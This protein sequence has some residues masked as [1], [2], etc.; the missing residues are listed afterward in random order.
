MIVVSVALLAVG[1]PMASAQQK[2]G[3]MVAE[4]GY[5]WMAG[6]WVA[7]TDQGQEIVY[8]QKWILD[9]HAGLV[10][11]KMGDF[12]YAGL[13][14]LKPGSDE[15]VQLGAD[16]KGGT[17]KGTWTEDYAGAVQRMEHT[18]PYG[19]VNKAEVVHSK[20]DAD[21]MTV[22]MY[23]LDDS[24]SRNAESWGKLTYKRK[25]AKP[26]GKAASSS[27]TGRL[28]A[29]LDEYDYD[30]L[31]GKWSASDNEGRTYELDWTWALD[32]NAVRVDLRSGDFK[33]HGMMV[34]SATQQEPIQFGA[35]TRGRTMKGTWTE[36]YEGAVLRG[37][38]LTPDGTL[39][40]AEQVITKIDNDTFKAREYMV[41]ADGW[42][43][44]SPSLEITF[45][46]RG[47]K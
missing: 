33:Y 15:V 10:D 39:L 19:E 24:G 41:E 45:K 34:L 22:A 28:G 9:R 35:D 30:W 42:R 21:T 29:L 40:K 31:I 20:V 3:D 11:L 32:K 47:A 23:G 44:S 14:M 2:L 5:E 36:E 8:E 7:S 37:E 27:A 13:I 25:A 6:R 38:Y 18:D 16:N 26:S 4:S 17:W 46:R 12:K 1:G 43:A